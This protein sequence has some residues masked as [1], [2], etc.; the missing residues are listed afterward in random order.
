MF[1]SPMLGLLFGIRDSNRLYAKW[2]LIMFICFYGTVI[3]LQPGTDGFIHQNAVYTN[4]LG[5]GIADFLSYSFGI[6]TFKTT[7]VQTDMYIHTVSFFV[8]SVLGMPKLFFIII[9]FVY[10][11]FYVSSL[12][13]VIKYTNKFKYDWFFYGFLTVF[14]VWKSIEG[15]NTVRTWTGLWVLFYSVL[16]FYETKKV[17]YFLLMLLPPH[18][19]IAYYLM[20]IP[21]WIVSIFGSWPKLFTVL[22]VVSFSFN[23][24][25]PTQVSEKLS[26]TEVGTQKVN[27]YYREEEWTSEEK[28]EESLSQGSAWYLALFKG[29]FHAWSVS[30]LAGFLIIFG[31]YSSKMTE[32]EAKLFGIGLL[33]KV[34]SNVSWFI[35]A[36]SVRSDIVAG[37]FI[38]AVFIMMYQRGAFHTQRNMVPFLHKVILVLILISFVPFIILKIS[39]LGEY[40]SLFMISLP[41]LIWFQGD[42]NISIKDGFKALL[43]F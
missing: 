35:Y 36:L 43:K 30:A 6:L 40:L 12:F 22:F 19:H 26:E 38:L 17:K 10:G 34:L 1:F 5:M 39:D 31:F 37:I 27:G 2:V 16:S 9:S 29:G 32:V 4:Y 3:N 7:A 23:I 20:A 28:L 13:K 24:L 33:A 11:Y 42:I 14:I 25:N 41:F 15:I 18:I 8:G 21:A